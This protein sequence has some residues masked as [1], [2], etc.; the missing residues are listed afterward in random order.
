MTA[1]FRIPV[2]RDWLLAIGFCDVSRPTL[3]QSMSKKEDQGRDK[4]K[5]SGGGGCISVLVP[6]GAAESVDCDV[7]VLTLNKRKG[8]V[9]IALETG[10]H[11]VPVYSFGETKLYR[12]WTSDSRIRRVLHR[13]QKFIGIGT[14]LVVGRGIFNYS[15]GGLPHREKL[16]TVIGR[17]IAVPCKGKGGFTEQD[18]DE[19][20]EKY[21]AALKDLYARYKPIYD[22]T[23]GDLQFR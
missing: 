9:K 12:Q 7:P 21:I 19:Y 20:H 22:P 4:L 2:W 11:L 23:S 1:N 17:P 8:F 18:V 3:I 5:K 13:L 16:T 10:C 15:F 6:G 14:P